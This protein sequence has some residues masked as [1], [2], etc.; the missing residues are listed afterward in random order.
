MFFS[1]LLL[2]TELRAF[3]EHASSNLF[4]PQ[5]PEGM[6]YRYVP[7]CSA[8]ASV[9]QNATHRMILLCRDI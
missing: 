2:E 9:F 5:P 1:P 7:L 6:D 8:F 3:L 4:L